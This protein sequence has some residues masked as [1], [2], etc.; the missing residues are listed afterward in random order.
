VSAAIACFLELAPAQ[1]GCV[2]LKDV[3]DHSIDEIAAELSLSLPAVKA[4][5]HRGRTALRRLDRG[6]EHAT[7]P[8]RQLGCA[9]AVRAPLQRP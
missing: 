4:A 5:L 6:A 7:R 9:E 2:I 1:R 8:S 3:L